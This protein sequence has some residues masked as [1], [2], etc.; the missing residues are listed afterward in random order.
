MSGR[1]I[2]ALESMKKNDDGQVSGTP[3]FEPAPSEFNAVDDD[4]P[5]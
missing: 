5:F 4:V 3:K 1:Q 2:Q